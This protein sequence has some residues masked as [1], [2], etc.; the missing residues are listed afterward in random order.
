MKTNKS[1]LDCEL[2]ELEQAIA[3]I[4]ADPEERAE[5]LKFQPIDVEMN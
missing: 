2:E 1:Q 3:E 4:V 5:M